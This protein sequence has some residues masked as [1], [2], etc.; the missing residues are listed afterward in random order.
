MGEL[1]SKEELAALGLTWDDEEE[2]V[3]VSKAAK[4]PA[5]DS[6][7]KPLIVPPV[8]SPAE[9]VLSQSEIDALLARFS[10]PD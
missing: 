6:D 5:S 4:L 3:P 10:S 9:A 7:E 1:I 8:A 2:A